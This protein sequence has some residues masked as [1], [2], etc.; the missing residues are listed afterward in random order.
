MPVLA[1]SMVFTAFTSFL[2]TVYVV[3]KQSGISFLTAMAGAAINIALNFLLIPSPLGVQ[4]AA[5]ATFISY[6]AVF[7]IRAANSR[8]YIRFKLYGGSVAAN[9][10]ITLVQTAFIVFELPFWI[11]VQ[12]LGVIAVAAVN[13]KYLFSALGRI[14]PALRR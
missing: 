10:A 4:G 3:T 13:Y 12:V 7:L 2:G 14:I 5:I 6:F 8:K 1:L 11:P 9:T